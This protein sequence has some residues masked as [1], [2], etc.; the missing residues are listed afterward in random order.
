MKE[1]IR[2]TLH[3][4]DLHMCII[5]TS[6][7]PYNYS[8]AHLIHPLLV[9]TGSEIA[10]VCVHVY[11]CDKSGVFKQIPEWDISALTTVYIARCSAEIMK[12][13]AIPKFTSLATILQ[14]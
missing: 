13:T 8:I 14:I 2:W 11:F 10:C 1:L 7:N 5:D 12:A 9:I 6:L 3:V 4:F